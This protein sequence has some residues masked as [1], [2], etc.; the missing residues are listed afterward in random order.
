LPFRPPPACLPS[1]R[2]TRLVANRRAIGAAS[3][4]V[5]NDRPH[6]DLYIADSSAATPEPPK[7]PI[8]DPGRRWAAPV[9]R[10]CQDGTERRSREGSLIIPS[11]RRLLRDLR[12]DCVLQTRE[13]LGGDEVLDDQPAEYLPSIWPRDAVGRAFCSTRRVR[14]VRSP[15][16]AARWCSRS[17]KRP[18]WHQRSGQAA[19][20][21]ASFAAIPS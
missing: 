21:S 14:S 10:R 5:G 16:F 11:A 9:G 19:S 2:S 1:D 12:R 17:L 15:A 20:M 6:E 18:L 7:V 13:T 8:A 3:V 4:A